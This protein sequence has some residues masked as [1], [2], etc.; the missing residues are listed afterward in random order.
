[1]IPYSHHGEVLD[2]GIINELRAP[3]GLAPI[4][5]ADM[6]NVAW[7]A[8][9]VKATGIKYAHIDYPLASEWNAAVD[10][11]NNLTATKENN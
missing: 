11:A 1:M 3:L 9:I 6:G 4:A 5:C 7:W 2:P 10:Y 8:E